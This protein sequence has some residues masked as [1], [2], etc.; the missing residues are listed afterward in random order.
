MFSSHCWHESRQSTAS[1]NR[2]RRCVLGGLR[3]CLEHIFLRPRL[4]DFRLQE[5]HRTKYFLFNSFLYMC[6]YTCFYVFH[7][8]KF[9]FFENVN[10]DHNRRPAIRKLIETI[11]LFF[12]AIEKHLAQVTERTSSSLYFL[13]IKHILPKT[14]VRVSQEA[15]AS[16][17][18]HLTTFGPPQKSAE[19]T[20]I[21]TIWHCHHTFSSSSTPPCTRKY[22]KVHQNMMRN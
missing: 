5:L 15:S 2:V 1:R 17:P 14:H 9:V 7:I 8:Y 4:V 6:V 11:F 13:H 19:P 21:P 22:K 16:L 3:S 18:D 10:T 12:L 20:G